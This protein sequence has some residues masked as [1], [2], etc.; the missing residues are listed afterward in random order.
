MNELLVKAQ[1]LSEMIKTSKEYLLAK[2][3]EQIQANDEKAQEMI[4]EYNEKRRDIA[5]KMQ[6]GKMSD[7]ETEVLR[8]EINEAFDKLM[9]YD[10]IKNY[11]EA[12]RDFE[13]LNQ[14]IMTIISGAGNE[15][16]S[17]SCSSCSGCH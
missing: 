3:T 17:G 2:E 10:V 4:K 11:V 1:E 13:L 6:Y 12:Q 5:V 9:E 7:E 16:C 14:Q 8:K 15:G